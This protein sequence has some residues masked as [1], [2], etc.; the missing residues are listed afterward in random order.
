MAQAESSH[1]DKILR[2]LGY[3]LFALVNRE[4]WPVDKFL[5]DLLECFGVVVRELDF[6]PHTGWCMRPFDR[7]DI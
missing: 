5:V 3:S 4:I 7:F 2:D 6:L 1:F